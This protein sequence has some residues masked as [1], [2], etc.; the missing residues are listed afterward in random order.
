MPAAENNLQAAGVS[1]VKEFSSAEYACNA[2][3]EYGSN[4]KLTSFS[5]ECPSSG[6]F[7]L[8]GNI[9][10]PTCIVS[11][12]LTIPTIT[13][14]VKESNG[15]IPVGNS[16]KYRCIT[17]GQ[18]T[19]DGPTQSMVCGAAGSFPSSPDSWPDCRD[20]MDCSE[21][22][23][24]PD[25][26]SKLEAS[27]S[28]GLK[29]FEYTQY[30]CQNGYSLEGVTHSGV[31]NNVFKLECG[32]GG[33][34]A[35]SIS[36]PTCLVSSC[37]SAVIPT[38]ANGLITDATGDTPVADEI[39]Y[40][41]TATT[42]VTDEGKTKSVLC[43]PDGT[44]NVPTTWPTC[45]DAVACTDSIP[46]PPG[47]S[48]LDASA[49]TVTNEFDVA[50]YA[51]KANH[52]Q[53]NGAADFMLT[54]GLAGT[55]PASPAWPTCDPVPIPCATVLTQDGFTTTAVAPIQSGS[56][57]VYTCSTA[58]EVH[59][60][61]K[62][63]EATCGIDGVIPSPTWPTCRAGVDCTD[64][65]PNPTGPSYLA[66][67][68]STVAKEFDSAT[69]LCNADYALEDGVADFKL[70]CGQ[71]GTFPASP[72]WPTCYPLCTTALTVPADAPYEAVEAS[73]SVGAGLKAPYQCTTSGEVSE[74]MKYVQVECGTDA[75]FIMP[76]AWPPC[77]AAL[78][79]PAPPAPPFSTNLAASTSS[80][81][82]EFDIALYSCNADF[83]LVGVPATVVGNIN[84]V[85]NKFELSC[86]VG[87]S[88]TT[89][90]DNDWPTCVSD[91]KRKKRFVEFDGLKA[92]ITYSIYA[93]VE[94]QWMYNTGVE[95]DVKDEKNFTSENL[96]FPKA[97]I[98]VFHER[99]ETV[100][101][102][103]SLGPIQLRN[104][105]YAICEQPMTTMFPHRCVKTFGKSFI[106]LIVLIVQLDTFSQLVTPTCLNEAVEGAWLKSLGFTYKKQ[107]PNW[108]DDTDVN[109]H[110]IPVG[111]GI[112]FYCSNNKTRPK[113]DIWDQ[114]N[115]DGIISAH[116]THTGAI[117]ITMN[118]GGKLSFY[119][120][121]EISINKS[122]P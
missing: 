89:I 102:D 24:E 54:C 60:G 64:T 100:L 48:N 35:T 20:I 95:N 116:C 111:G 40:H 11:N 47:E 75:N 96:L 120:Y 10:W 65:P 113:K 105:V 7:P 86:G 28:T 41:C 90:T 44:F 31:S 15:P 62:I 32:G 110:M 71:G 98:D 17:D 106:I 69:Y 88:F 67:S 29:E 85:T 63:V 107:P 5:V 52:Q 26:N 91:A 46:A 93:F 79:C 57:I 78:D 122:H 27:T 68:A 9:S 103:G 77:H 81:L 13:G 50:T 2:D 53:A 4:P 49:S 1:S 73:T 8:T 66:N 59:D 12:C 61:G 21:T 70:A 38:A 92:D 74:T 51:C 101:G 97:V 18:V 99:I 82:K 37:L 84:T 34:Y 16:V 108:M 118:P 23:P 36:W 19:V 43:Q 56:K 14:F 119:P 80:G 112:E 83:T 45:R 30:T 121:D 55:F 6:S 72:T 104:P 115:E 87:G 39:S 114:D 76:V 117:S 22:A 94:T 33:T 25:V 3:G 42:Q 58:G 109:R